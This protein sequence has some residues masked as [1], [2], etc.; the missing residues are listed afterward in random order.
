MGWQFDLDF[1]KHLVSTPGTMNPVTAIAFIISGFS[2]WFFTG[3]VANKTAYV[4][5]ALVLLIGILKFSNIAFGLNF[6]IDS[7][8]YTDK[9]LQE[10][11]DNQPNQMAPNTAFCFI[12]TGM[13]LILFRHQTTNKNKASHYFALII[14]LMSLLSLLGYIYRVESFYGFLTYIP[15]AVSTAICF[16][17]FSMA[18]FFADAGKG[19]MKEFTSTLSGSVMPV[20]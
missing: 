18:V 9:L 8:L 3:K 11:T 12:L 4:L 17:I 1:L 2:L 19:I 16:F 20:Y 14:A 13:T 15:M 7:L 10:N 6:K 5:A